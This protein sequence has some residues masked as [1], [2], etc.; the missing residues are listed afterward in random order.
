MP[1][2]R[3]GGAPHGEK[4]KFTQYKTFGIVSSPRQKNGGGRILRKTG[5]PERRPRPYPRKLNC[6]FPAVR[7]PRA[8]IMPISA[9]ME[10]RRSSP[11]CDGF[12]SRLYPYLQG[13][14]R[15]ITARRASQN[16]YA[17]YPGARRR[18]YYSCS[19]CLKIR[20]LRMGGTDIRT[21]R[22]DGIPL[23]CAALLGADCAYRDRTPF[24]RKKADG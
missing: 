22:T 2:E 16:I 7:R 20:R 11:Q 1:F 17:G 12:K 6:A 18:F 5:N 23:C 13:S 10:L 8:A 14:N 9:E 4:G 21:N 24:A 19:S 3:G 15:G